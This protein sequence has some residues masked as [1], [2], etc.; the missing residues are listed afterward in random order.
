MATWVVL[1]G[2]YA[3]AEENQHIA[4]SY[5]W[6]IESYAGIV[7]GHDDLPLW[8]HANRW[9][10]V[11]P[12]GSQ[13]GLGSRL[14]GDYPLS[15]ELRVSGTLHVTVRATSDQHLR[16]VSLPEVSGE[17]R[18]RPLVA[19]IGRFRQSI[20]TPPAG[21]STGS[22]AVSPNA[23][24][25]PKLQFAVPEYTSIPFTRE[26]LYLKGGIAHGWLNDDRYVDNVYLHEKYLFAKIEL[27][28][29][30][31][32]HGGLIH[33]AQ[34][35]GT[36]PDGTESPVGLESYWNVFR[37]RAAGDDGLEMDQLNKEGNHLG[38][39]DLG[40]GYEIA[41]WD[42]QGY[43]QHFGEDASGTK[44]WRNGTDGLW[45]LVVDWK[46]PLYRVRGVYEYLNTLDQ[47]GPYHNDPSDPTVV[48]GG[49]DS[50][51]HH[52]FY[53]TGW[54]YSDA[55]IGNALFGFSGRGGDRRIDEN[56]IIA[57][58][59]GA[60]LAFSEK[61]SARAL[62]TFRESYPAYASE[63]AVSSGSAHSTHLLLEGS[64]PLG[65]TGYSLTSGV[66]SDFWSDDTSASWGMLLSVSRVL[67]N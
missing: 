23:L 55:V 10:V 4:S 27:P 6:S 12:F 22:M 53:R 13:A 26:Y 29:G 67:G 63:S 57:H 59:F 41:D 25:I 56:R 24:P 11:R 15:S 54:T 58:H 45:G 49:R 48:L 65:E 44:N 5:G 7:A 47:S 60:S 43:Y 21:L 38:T 51:Y 61:A 20:G 19:R 3:F 35:G 18:Y 42:F 1:W 8:L 2:L 28:F 62:L 37:I 64:F 31:R 36:A 14:S 33:E 30:V 52:S 50:Y 39:W 16:N 34:W 46:G 9:G 32:L 40:I 17:L 66:A